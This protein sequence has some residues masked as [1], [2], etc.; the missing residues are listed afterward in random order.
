MEEKHTFRNIFIVASVILIAVSTYGR[1]YATKVDEYYDLVNQAEDARNASVDELNECSDL[2]LDVWDHSLAKIQDPKTN[3]YTCPNGVF[4]EDFNEALDNL[5]ADS[6]FQEKLD[7][8]SDQQMELRRLE[9]KLENPPN[10]EEEFNDV[11]LEYLDNY[12]EVSMAVIN[13]NG[14]FIEVSE[15]INHLNVEGNELQME[16]DSFE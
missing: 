6:V 1:Y 5:Y 7:V 9:R 11:F 13:P 2:L 3:P 16:L 12:I 8:I 14:S 4:L 15:Q 10:L